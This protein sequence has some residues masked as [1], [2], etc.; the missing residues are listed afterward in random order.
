[1][2]LFEVK[3]TI[4]IRVQTTEM[5]FKSAGENIENQL[6]YDIHHCVARPLFELVPVDTSTRIFVSETY[7]ICNPIICDY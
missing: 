3:I 7:D 6:E 4:W 1:M 2:K 5:I